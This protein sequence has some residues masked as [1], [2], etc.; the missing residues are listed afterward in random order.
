MHNELRSRVAK[1][2]EAGQP[3][4]EHDDDHYDHDYIIDHAT[5]IIRRWSGV[6][7]A[8]L[9]LEQR[10]GSRGSKMGGPVH[11]WPWFGEHCDDDGDVEG[12]GDDDYLEIVIYDIMM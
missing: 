7:Y 3:K 5:L 12:L 9:G 8:R 2:E 1:G 11:I 6:W 10:A 4:V